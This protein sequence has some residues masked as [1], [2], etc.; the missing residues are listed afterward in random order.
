[1]SDASNDY[2]LLD[3][4]IEHA[5][6][7]N[8][9]AVFPFAAHWDSRRMQAIANE[10]NLSETVFVGEMAGANRFPIRIF[11]PTAEL[12]FA[13]HPTVGTAHLLAH[14]ALVRRDQPLVLKAGV[15]PLEVGFDGSLARFTTAQPVAISESSLNRTRAAAL[16]GLP[17][18]AVIGNP[19]LA[20]CGLP[21]HL[22][23]LSSL[24]DLARAIPNPS[25]WSRWVTPS[26]QEALYM[27]VAQPTTT[28]GGTLRSRM[29]SMENSLR[30]DAA[31]G[32]AAAALVGALTAGKSWSG[33]WQWCIEQG[34]EMGRPSRIHGEVERNSDAITAIRIAG[35][36]VLVG[37]GTIFL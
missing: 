35:E 8:P 10:L 34:V 19:V 13:G 2:Y 9:L 26:G 6:A 30:E 22:V 24:D 29:F 15:G 25:D 3:V 14:L 7:G 21:F 20:S 17:E 36:A 31:T 5:F 1:M 16:L 27:Y 33:R 23:E 28:P 12:P 18:S 11:T 37:K 32:S 4:F